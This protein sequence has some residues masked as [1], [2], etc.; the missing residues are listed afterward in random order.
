MLKRVNPASF[1]ALF[2]LAGWLRTGLVWAHSPGH[3]HATT[4]MKVHR[5]LIA[6]PERS[7]L[8]ATVVT[9][10]DTIIFPVYDGKV[11]TPPTSMPHNLRLLG[12]VHIANHNLLNDVHDRAAFGGFDAM[13][14]IGAA[15]LV[16]E[17][18]DGSLNVLL[19]LPELHEHCV[20]CRTVHFF[21]RSMSAK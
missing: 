7:G 9:V 2:L 3:R 15:Y 21:F 16:T 8:F 12:N 20:S 19:S 11:S 13:S 6:A 18:G 10:G 4:T 5:T 17:S 14:N 1:V